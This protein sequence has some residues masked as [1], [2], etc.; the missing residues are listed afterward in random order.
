MARRALASLVLVVF[1]GSAC[2]GDASSHGRSLIIARA[3]DADNLLPPV[4]RTLV[5]KAVADALFDKLADIGPQLNTIGD[6]GF[7]PRLAQR[8]EWSPDSLQVT[9]HLNPRA[10]W[11]DGRPVRASDVRFAFSVYTDTVVGASGGGDLRLALDSISVADSLTAIAWFK[12]RSPEH[13]YILVTTLVPLPE[14]LLGKTPRDSLGTSAFGRQPV[15]SGPFRLVRWQPQERIE[16]AAVDS[17]YRGRAKIDRIIY[18][19]SPDMAAASR[20]FLAGEADFLEQLTPDVAADAAKHSDLRVVPYGAFD[21]GFVRLNLRD[22]ATARPHP[23][24]GDRALRRALTMALDRREMVHSVFDSLA[25]VGIGPFVRAQWSSDTTLAQLPFDRPAAA[26]ALDSLGWRA[27]P[28]SRRARNGRPLAFTVLVPSSSR[29]RGRLAVLL[30]EQLRQ[31][32]VK[33]NIEALDFTAFIARLHKHDFDA[34]VDGIHPS[35]SPSG[36]RDSWSSAGIRKGTGPNYSW[37]ANPGFDAQVDSAV[38]SI[39]VRTARAHYRAA[40]QIIIDDA[41]AIWLYE[42]VAMA[43]VN[44]RLRTG[45]LHPN[46]WWS[47]LAEWTVVRP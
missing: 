15:G 17:F 7:R 27:G 34:L 19:V 32:G 36:V 4:G 12:G 26:R 14:H 37:Y 23:L 6:G 22:G 3:A 25:L 2:A 8:W 28:D 44:K 11:H 21:Y 29:N 46:A 41:A 24:F 40:Y 39:D 10:R 47:D 9:F 31:L 30:Q 16:I 5:G 20:K 33:V 18:T 38:N 35:E 43:G 13:F 45:T 1:A 42:P